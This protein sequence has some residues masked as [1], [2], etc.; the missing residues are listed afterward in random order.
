[1]ALVNQV[2][3]NTTIYVAILYF[4]FIVIYHIVA[5]HCG[6]TIE[7]VWNAIL[8]PN[9]GVVVQRYD[10]G[11][12]DVAYNYAEFLESLLGEFDITEQ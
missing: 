9:K 10:L 8:R 12:P 7:R 3:I 4:I 5:S 11:I 6:I 2:V 1:M